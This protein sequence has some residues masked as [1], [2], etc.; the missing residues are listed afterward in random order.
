M[1]THGLTAEF[2]AFSDSR[3]V[4]QLMGT[5]VHYCVK[6]ILQKEQVKIVAEDKPNVRI[7]K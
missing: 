2:L 4:P 7:S 6:N 1:T 5:K 3:Y